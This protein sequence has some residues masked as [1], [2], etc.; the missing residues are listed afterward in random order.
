VTSTDF[1]NKTKQKRKIY[2][3]IGALITLV[4]PFIIMLL[5]H[6]DSL[7]H[8]QSLCP[9]KMLTGFPCPGCG[10]TKSLVYFY[11]GEVY[12]SLSFHILGPFVVLFCLLTIIILL[13]ELKTG[14][15]Y[16]NV[17][18]YNQKAAY[19]LAIFLG[20]YHLIRLIYFVQSH[21]WNEILH[22]SIWK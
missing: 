4:I 19:A 17:F 2:G 20:V 12:K 21:S 9:F 18:I 7:D 13:L 15:E 3:I 10:I 16:F 8:E 1:I 14:R 6:G 22:E 11:Q 5:S